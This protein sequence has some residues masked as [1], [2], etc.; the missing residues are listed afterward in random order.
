VAI[1]DLANRY[2]QDH[3]PWDSTKNNPQKA[4]EQL[5]T[6]LWAGKVCV[7]LLK[8]ILPIVAEQTENMLQIG[9]FTFQ[10]VLKPFQND[11]T[12]S[13][14]TRLFERLDMK[15][16]QQMINTNH[17]NISTNTSPTISENTVPANLINIDDFTK[18]D[19]RAAFVLESK[20][21]LGADKLISLTLDVGPLGKRHVFTGL[22][23][24][25]EPPELLGKTVVLVY[26]LAP[27]KMKFG[28]SEGMILAAGEEKPVPLIL[29]GVKPGDQIR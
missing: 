13:T 7:G 15:K 3:A 9:S 10:N 8:P 5:T 24:H 29:N 2:L 20:P 12:I 25:V 18:V 27:R 16:V 23:P 28:I 1:A 26:N 21:V 22:R 14:Y 11:H 19:L 17:E 4:H 6:A